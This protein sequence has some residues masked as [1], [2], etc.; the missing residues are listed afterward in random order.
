MVSDIKK[1][2]STFNIML[3]KFIRWWALYIF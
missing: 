1:N 3:K 2:T